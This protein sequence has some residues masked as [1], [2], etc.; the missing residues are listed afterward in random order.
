MKQLGWLF[1]GIVIGAVLLYLLKGCDGGSSKIK[2][3]DTVTTVEV[4]YDTITDKVIE[5]VKTK[6]DT[7]F[8]IKTDTLR[9]TTYV[10]R[11]YYNYK[12]Y[13][14]KY[15]DSNVSIDLQAGIWQ[16]SLDIVK[17]EYETYNT[18]KTITNT[19]T[20]TKTYD[21]KIWTGGSVNFN[22]VA[23][24]VSV[25][26]GQHQFGATRTILSDYEMDEAE[27]WGV[28]YQYRLFER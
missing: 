28:R 10:Y 12:W 26:I 16:N 23:V 22:E 20:K 25:D 18:T 19:I 2:I 21:F 15:K 24:D 4:K 7:V 14:Y 27:K 9:D 6:P 5:K 3:I 8:L 17:L 1:S 11:D 13:P